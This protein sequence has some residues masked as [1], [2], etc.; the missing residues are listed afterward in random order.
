MERVVIIRVRD[1]MIAD[2]AYFLFLVDKRSVFLQCTVR[3]QYC[4]FV[5][6]TVSPMVSLASPSHAFNIQHYL[7]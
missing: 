7:F 6:E 3:L 4:T 2:S 1:S 5:C